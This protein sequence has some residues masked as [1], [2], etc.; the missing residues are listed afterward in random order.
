MPSR[1]GA[2]LIVDDLGSS[3]DGRHREGNPADDVASIIR[4]RVAGRSQ[5]A[6]QSP[7]SK[8][9]TA[10]CEPRSTNSVASTSWSTMRAT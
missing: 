9:H 5:A 6:S 3:L 8:A 10:W 4:S 7:I 2:S 1:E